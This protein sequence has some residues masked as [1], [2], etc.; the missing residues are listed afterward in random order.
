[1]LKEF[2]QFALKGN[3]LDLA[4]AVIIGGAFGK[5]VSS[6]VSDIIMPPLGLLLRGVDFSNL[7]IALDGKH[8]DTLTAAKA[9]GAPT[10]NYGL[11]LNS[12]IDFAVIAFCIFLIVQQVNRWTAEKPAAPTTKECPECA[13]MIP[14]KARRCPQCTAVLAT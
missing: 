10:L 11:F 12:A 8:Y 4:V 5:I 3:V 6:V 14:I 13:M 7:F 9:A 1:M 2:K